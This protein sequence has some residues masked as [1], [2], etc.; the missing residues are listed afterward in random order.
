MWAWKQASKQ[1]SSIFFASVPA[2]RHLPGAP[3]L[4]SLDIAI[5]PVSGNQPLSLPIVLVHISGYCSN[6]KQTRI[7]IKNYKIL[8]IIYFL[9]HELIV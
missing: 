2:S 6:R 4:A 3:G 8:Q 1:L 9:E 7:D 5:Y